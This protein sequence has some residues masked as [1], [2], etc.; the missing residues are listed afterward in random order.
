MRSHHPLEAAGE[1]AFC[2]RRIHPPR[3][4]PWEYL[5]HSPWGPH[6]LAQCLTRAALL[7]GRRGAGLATSIPLHMRHHVNGSAVS[8]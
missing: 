7:C 1:L 4:P 2:C 5:L 3:V 6:P 8:V